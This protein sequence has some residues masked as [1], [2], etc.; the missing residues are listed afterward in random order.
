MILL[1]EWSFKYVLSVKKQQVDTVD[2]NENRQTLLTEAEGRNDSK[3]NWNRMQINEHGCSNR[4]SQLLTKKVFE[5]RLAL[6]YES[7]ILRVI[8]TTRTA[9]TCTL[10]DF[11][12]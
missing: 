6:L 4:V 10:L 12:V 2:E 9:S 1:F 8:H 7:F 3:N 11:L 5:A